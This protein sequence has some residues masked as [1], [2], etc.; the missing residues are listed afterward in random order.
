MKRARWQPSEEWRER[1]ETQVQACC[2]REGVNVL[3]A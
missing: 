3:L 2:Q 1:G